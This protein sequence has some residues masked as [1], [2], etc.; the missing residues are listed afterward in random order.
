MRALAD[1]D[2]AIS[3]AEILEMVTVN[4]ARALG[5]TGKLGELSPGALADLVAIPFAG[6]SPNVFEAVLQHTGAVSACLI[7]GRWAIPPG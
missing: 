5:L 6:K 1:L 4:A 2:Q 3:P 7:E